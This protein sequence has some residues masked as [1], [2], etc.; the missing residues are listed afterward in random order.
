MF[1]LSLYTP[2]PCLS[3]PLVYFLSL[4]SRTCKSQSWPAFSLYTA[5][6]RTETV[7]LTAYHMEMVGLAAYRM[8]TVGLAA[9]ELIAWGAHLTH[10]HQ[11]H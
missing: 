1:P 9:L 7:G 6:Y 10:V 4:L 3:Q 5:A 11:G 2:G 8:K